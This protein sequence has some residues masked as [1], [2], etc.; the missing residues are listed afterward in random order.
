M[1]HD[2]SLRNFGACLI[3][4]FLGVL[5]GSIAWS[6]DDALREVLQSRYAVMKAAMA[7][8]DGAAMTK[9]LAPDFMSVDVSGKLETASQLIAEV[10]GL[11]PDPNKSSETTLISL[12]PDA[13]RVI[14]EQ[15]YHMKT[16]RTA[17]DGTQ[18][19]VELITLSTDTWIKPADVW[20][21]ERTVTNELSYFD[22]GLLV[23]HKLK[24]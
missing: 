14:V 23:A 22:N 9:M 3:L 12:G 11:K 19:N 20:L 10:N 7:A 17:G 2:R 5:V 24:P 21:M 15:Q 8:H 13:N 16:V 6:A 4:C 18:H 1:R